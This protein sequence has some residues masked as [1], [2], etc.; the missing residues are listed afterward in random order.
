MHRYLG[1]IAIGAFVIGLIPA[2]ASAPPCT[3][4]GTRHAD[5]RVGTN[6]R[7][8]ICVRNGRDYVQGKAGKDYIRGSGQNDT[9]VG[10]DGR[11]VVRGGGGN[12]RI[13]VVDGKPDDVVKGEAGRDRCF[14]DQGDKLY[15]EVRFGETHSYPFATVDAMTNALAGSITQAQDAQRLLLTI[16]LAL[17]PGQPPHIKDICDP[18]T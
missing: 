1:V 7:D 4:R 11:D 13:F 14:G 2:S 16:C 10:G 5:S 17:P 8:V 15:C 9:L 18:I 3:I 6:H 12:D